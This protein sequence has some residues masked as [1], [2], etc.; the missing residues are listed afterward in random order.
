MSEPTQY[1]HEMTARLKYII[2]EL[3]QL[4]IGLYSRHAGCACS[5]QSLCPHHMLVDD[6]I[7]EGINKLMGAV[8]EAQREE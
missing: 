2:G 6:Q 7:L 8:R 5:E 4:D 3:R 1:D